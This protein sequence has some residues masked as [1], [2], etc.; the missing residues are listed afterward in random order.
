MDFFRFDNNIADMEKDAIR[1]VIADDH[2]IIRM[3]IR[4][5]LETNPKYVVV[6]EAENG[7]HAVSLVQKLQPDVILL[8]INMPVLD[9]IQAA[10]I[11]SS[12][13]PKTK[14]VILTMHDD[15]A[16]AQWAIKAGACSVLLKGCGRDEIL[17]AI[18][19][20]ARM[21]QNEPLAV[22]EPA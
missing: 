22:T 14:V 21:R 5:L 4:F 16:Y 15:P 19:C 1:L 3:S 11:I 9:G 8:D 12:R 20:N 10:R 6:G 7:L 2:P 17:D 18:W 13:F